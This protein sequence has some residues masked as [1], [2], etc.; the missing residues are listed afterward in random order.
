MNS[1]TS[2]RRPSRSVR[3]FVTCDINFLSTVE[4][5]AVASFHVSLASPAVYQNLTEVAYVSSADK[6]YI[7]ELLRFSQNVTLWFILQWNHIYILQNV[8]FR[9]AN[10]RL[11]FKSENCRYIATLTISFHP[12]PSLHHNITFL[13]SVGCNSQCV[14]PPQR[15][16]HRV[17]NHYNSLRHNASS[18]YRT[19]R[20]SSSSVTAC[21]FLLQQWHGRDISSDLHIKYCTIPWVCFPNIH[22]MVGVKSKNMVLHSFSTGGKKIRSSSQS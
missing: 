8:R 13:P 10:F 17:L 2:V 3:Y 1:Q 5:A 19:A 7:T 15:Q 4:W 21:N 9:K 22:E 20:R 11:G 12:L 16:F 14:R 18:L 6:L